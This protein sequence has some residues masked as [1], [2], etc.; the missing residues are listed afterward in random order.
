MS[1]GVL[2]TDI[3][4]PVII[5]K[6]Q[7]ALSRQMCARVLHCARDSITQS[8]L[9]EKCCRRSPDGVEMDKFETQISCPSRKCK[10]R[11]LLAC[12]RFPQGRDAN[13]TKRFLLPESGAGGL[14]KQARVVQRRDARDDGGVG[15]HAAHQSVVQVVRGRIGVPGLVGVGVV[16][17]SGIV[18][19]A[20]VRV[21]VSLRDLLAGGEGRSYFSAC[22]P[23]L[24]LSANCCRTPTFVSPSAIC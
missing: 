5:G 13:V 23:R 7:S 20:F 12:S 17:R 2:T 4:G 21:A 19:L 10:R 3:H 22:T 11:A 6:R 1:V 16:L 8:T 18:Q 14:V 15:R 9:G 24:S